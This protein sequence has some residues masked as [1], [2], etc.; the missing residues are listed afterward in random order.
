MALR[1]LETLHQLADGHVFLRGKT[2]RLVLEIV[3][4]QFQC[5]SGFVLGRRAGATACGDGGGGAGLGDR[6]G[7]LHRFG[8]DLGIAA[9]PFDPLC[10]VDVFDGCAGLV[11]SHLEGRLQD[12][13]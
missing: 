7:W 5:P 1:K 2:G 8:L 9:V 10:R 13:A 12:G 3:H 4:D 6:W 11:V